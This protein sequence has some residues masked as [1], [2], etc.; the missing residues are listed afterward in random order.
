[1]FLDLL[2]KAEKLA[3]WFIETADSVDFQS[4]QWEALFLFK[5]SSAGIY[6][7]AGAIYKLV[8]MVLY[9]HD[10]PPTLSYSSVQ[11]MLLFSHFAIHLLDQSFDSVKL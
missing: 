1:M 3:L 11:G 8:N 4:D 2:S 10:S 9:S 7:F 5:V 6:S